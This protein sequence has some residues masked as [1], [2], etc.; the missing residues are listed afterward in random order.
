MRDNM[1]QISM[2]SIKVYH[3]KHKK[4][5]ILSEITP[6]YGNWLEVLV[7]DWGERFG[8]VKNQV[9]AEIS[10]IDIDNYKFVELRKSRFEKVFTI[11]GK[12][13]IQGFE[14]HILLKDDAVP[15]SHKA[16]PVPFALRASIDDKIESLVKEEKIVKINYSEWASPI[17]SVKKADES[18]RMCVHFKRTVNNAVVVPTSLEA[19][20]LKILHLAHPGIVHT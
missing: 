18:L 14:A 19:K 11:D 5:Q 17:V 3:T 1:F 6:F 20:V 9:T 10:T 16:Y 4:T 15:I 13:T 7:P 8:I 2:Q 12:Q